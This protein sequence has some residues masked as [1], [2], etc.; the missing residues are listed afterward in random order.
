[1]SLQEKFNELCL[2]QRLQCYISIN[3]SLNVNE[4]VA[5]LIRI[6]LFTSTNNK[7]VSGHNAS[8]PVN[9]N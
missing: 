1:M 7:K 4:N 6:Y 2:I 8:A 9:Y 5:G 3:S